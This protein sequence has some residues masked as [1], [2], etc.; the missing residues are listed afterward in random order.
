VT[1]LSIMAR[2]VVEV[3]YT[4]QYAVNQSNLVCESRE[5]KETVS[6]F[7]L[8]LIADLLAA[9]NAILGKKMLSDYVPDRRPYLFCVGLV[10]VPFAFIGIG[11]L[12]SL[13]LKYTLTAV[14]VGV[15]YILAGHF[16]Y[17]AM[18]AGQPSRLS[19]LFRLSAV[20]TLILSAA[21]LNERLTVGQYTGFGLAFLMGVGL[22]TERGPG[23][24]GA[25]DALASALCGAVSGTLAL[26]LL[27][28]YSVWETFCATRIGV[29]IGMLPLT[30]WQ[31]TREVGVALLA[32]RRRYRITLIGEQ[33]MRLVSL[34]LHNMAVAGIGSATL[35]AVLS[36][37]IPV[38]VWLMAV[39]TRQESP[40]GPYAGRR[41]LAMVTFLVSAYL[42]AA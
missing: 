23:S 2:Y 34:F 3:S 30:G 29:V 10:S 36:G 11:Y 27:Q 26:Y 15:A 28:S 39:L 7:V 1:G 37:F 41:L 9:G 38:Y 42:M 24:G 32:L 33:L 5:R 31:R 14:V 16:Y 6:W 17:R 4:A 18:S 21:V 19:M 25:W 22:I 20:F 13:P 40:H 35:V 8:K 12:T